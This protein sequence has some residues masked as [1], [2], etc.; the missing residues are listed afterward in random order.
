MD[1]FVADGIF[2][3]ASPDRVFSALLD[4]EE[5]CVWMDADEASSESKLGGK[6]FARRTDGS[7]VKGTI[8]A[9]KPGDFLQIGQYYWES[10]GLQRGPMKLS[11]KLEPRHGGVW[12][13]I[14]VDDLDC[15]SNWKQ[16]AQDTRKELVQSTVTL[17]RHIEQI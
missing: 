2:V 13:T 5:I 8:E 16:F 4:P 17:K 14:R 7:T 11:C 12:I 15:A 3:D 9:H 10:E 1:N 6:F